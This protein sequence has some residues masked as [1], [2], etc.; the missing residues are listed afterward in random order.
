MKIWTLQANRLGLLAISA[1]MVGG[2]LLFLP[3]APARAE[4]IL[5]EQ[6]TM[7]PA[8]DEYTFSGTAGQAVTIR[9]TSDEIDPV[10]ELL[11]PD[12]QQIAYND[13]FSRTLNSAII[14]TLPTTGDYKIVA[15]S[16]SGEGGRYSVTVQPS[17]SYELSYS[18]A[19]NFYMEGRYQEAVDAFSEA[20]AID[21]NQASAYADRAEARWGLFYTQQGE[22]MNPEQPPEPSPELKAAIIADYQQAADLYEQA[23]ETETAQ[24]LRDQISSMQTNE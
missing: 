7:Q 17:T 21:P 4:V 1:A 11:G 19:W 14:I 10:L 23:G 13:D 12:G 24:I 6:G 20:I 22:N 5:Q 9:M 15:R 8:Q 18:K 2:A 3:V 16:F